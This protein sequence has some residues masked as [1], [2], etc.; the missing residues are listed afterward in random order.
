LGAEVV[1]GTLRAPTGE[2]LGLDP[3]T[4]MLAW[5]SSTKRGAAVHRLLPVR[6]RAPF[7]GETE[8]GLLDGRGALRLGRGTR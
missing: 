7:G 8:Q 1:G 3:A 5:L 6:G 4:G 2:A